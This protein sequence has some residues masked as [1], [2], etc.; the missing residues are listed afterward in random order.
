M[1]KIDVSDHVAWIDLR[2]FRRRE[3]GDDNIDLFLADVFGQLVGKDLFVLFHQDL[4]ALERFEW[5]F[6]L[7]VQ[8][9]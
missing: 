5:P 2:Q 7:V 6:Q 9:E 8:A 4:Q 1:K 3:A